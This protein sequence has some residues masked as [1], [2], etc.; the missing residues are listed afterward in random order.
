MLCLANVE[1]LVAF[2]GYAYAHF[3]FGS[4]S[5]ALK[6][7]SLSQSSIIGF[8]TSPQKYGYNDTGV[9]SGN[10]LSFTMDTARYVIV[11][12]ADVGEVIIAADPLETNKPA[13]SGTGIFNVVSRYGADNTGSTVTTAAFRSALHDAGIRGQ[14]S[15]VYV[16]PGVYY[17][18]NL[19]LPSSTSLYLE[20]G[21]SLL[22]TGNRSDYTKDWTKTSQGLDGTEWIRTAHNTHDIKICGRGTIDVRGDY[23]QKIGKFIAHA[24]VPL[25]TTQF[26]FDGPLI[27]DGGSWTLIPT[28]SSH[29]TVDHAK[30]FNRMDLGEVG[31]EFFTK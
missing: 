31:C 24:V 28:R 17:I 16:P 1:L 25:N 13:S 23:G 27:R 30:I 4:G 7:T 10:T 18:G 21:S 8:I 5:V 9:V 26:T 3:S 6:V 20:A 29:V 14:G 15:I 12:I 22:F 2:D 11:R 19:I